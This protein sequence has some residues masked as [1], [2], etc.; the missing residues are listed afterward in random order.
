VKEAL[1]AVAEITG[2]DTVSADTVSHGVLPL[3]V[4]VRAGVVCA[5]P[6]GLDRTARFDRLEIAA[7]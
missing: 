5:W 6:D 3:D 4:T 1:C 7:G 2:D